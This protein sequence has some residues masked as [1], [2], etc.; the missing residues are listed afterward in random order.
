[1]PEKE[2]EVIENQ[3]PPE[4]LAIM[5]EIET[6]KNVS[7]DFRG[8]R[9]KKRAEELQG[10][11]DV[12][13]KKPP[14]IKPEIIQEE[15]KSEITDVEINTPL[16]K[17][18]INKPVEEKAGEE[19]VD[20]F[21]NFEN[22]IKTAKEFEIE[23]KEPKDLK[24]VFNIIKEKEIKL[25][26][27][28]PKLEDLTQKTTFLETL[29]TNMPPE[30][31]NAFTAWANNDPNWKAKLTEVTEV[32]FDLNTPVG[33]IDKRELANFF[34]DEEYSVEEWDELDEKAKKNQIK[35]AEQLYT[36]RQ[37]TFLSYRDNV[38]KSN[39]E[40]K[41]N[42]VKSVDDSITELKKSNPNIN[43]DNVN[44]VKT[45]MLKGVK[46]YLFDKNGNYQKDAAKKIADSMYAEPTIAALA[47]ELEKQ[48]AIAMR[49]GEAKGL[50]KAL[51]VGKEEARVTG[52]E[53]TE[54]LRK[55]LVQSKTGFLKGNFMQ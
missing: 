40:K 2:N 14:E 1:M 17:M 10:K 51:I 3:L 55:K 49:T 42:F 32:P 45:Q 36:A 23:L 4:A 6:L 48:V 38:R 22:V 21:A 5:Q 28:E 52:T 41:G 50:E 34:G 16:L 7:K 19:G 8:T 35:S 30:F 20:D 31:G 25:K 18:K 15:K 39:D 29:I 46:D 54:D 11:L 37:N 43:E 53:K 13:L 44:K 24:K 27:Y 33:K 9:S 12:L 47:Q 26:E